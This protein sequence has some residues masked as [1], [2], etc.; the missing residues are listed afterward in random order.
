MTLVQVMQAKPTHPAVVSIGPEQTVQDAI[1]LLCRHRIGVL[2]V[3]QPQS[4]RI[5]GI[6]SERD[7]LNSLCT[8]HHRD[9]EKTLVRDI[10]TTEVIVAD[11]SERASAALRVMSERHIRHLPV[12]DGERLIGVV[13]IGDVVRDLY[14]EDEVRILSLGDYLGGTYGNSVF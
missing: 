9:P 13:T 14:E 5:V 11:V 4:H 6:C 8:S 12:L 10:M 2:I 7:V 3:L 1:D